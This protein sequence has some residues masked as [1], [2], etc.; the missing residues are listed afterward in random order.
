M[1]N[2]TEKKLSK[3]HELLTDKLTDIVKREDVSSAELNVVRQFLRDNNIDGLPVEGTA[4]GE[5][6]S[7]LPDDFKAA[8]NLKK[9]N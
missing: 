3:L 2:K 9:A 7:Q 1:S 8:Y 6:V 4:L 5:L